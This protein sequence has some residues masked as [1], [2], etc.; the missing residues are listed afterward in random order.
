LD[1]NDC[2][3]LRTE[4]G[5]TTEPT[6]PLPNPLIFK[7]ENFRTFDDGTPSSLDIRTEDGSPLILIKGTGEAVWAKTRVEK[8]QLIRTYL[9][10]RIRTELLALGII[11]GFPVIRPA[12]LVPAF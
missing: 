10:N 4:F 7:P 6:A 12:S 2:Q 5:F 11:S 8:D 1:E 3:T 9:I